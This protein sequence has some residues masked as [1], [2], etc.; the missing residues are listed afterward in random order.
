[1]SKEEAND[2]RIFRREVRFHLNRTSD[3]TSA[4]IADGS[5][6]DPALLVSDTYAAILLLRT[7][8]VD[9][10]ERGNK[11]APCPVILSHQM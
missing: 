8:F 6:E 2:A 7:Y 3:A 4:A 1:M 5:E 11:L 9:F 10:Y